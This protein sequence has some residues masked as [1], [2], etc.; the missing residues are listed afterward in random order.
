[1]K[2][3]VT[4]SVS[5]LMLAAFLLAASSG[6]VAWGQVLKKQENQPVQLRAGIDGGIDAHESGAICCS[7][8]ATVTSSFTVENN[9]GPGE[10]GTLTPKP[11]APNGSKN[12]GRWNTE[13]Q[14]FNVHNGRITLGGTTNH[15]GHRTTN[16]NSGL[17]RVRAAVSV[18]ASKNDLSTTSH[19]DKHNSTHTGY[20]QDGQG[21]WHQ[22]SSHSETASCPQVVVSIST[23]T[24]PD[25]TGVTASNTDPTYSNPTVITVNAANMTSDTPWWLQQ[26][27]FMSNPWYFYNTTFVPNSDCTLSVAFNWKKPTVSCHGQHPNTSPSWGESSGIASN[28]I[29]YEQ[30]RWGTSS[31]QGGFVDARIIV[32]AGSDIRL[33]GADGAGMSIAAAGTNGGSKKFYLDLPAAHYTLMNDKDVAF[34]NIE[35]SNRAPLGDSAVFGVNTQL[36]TD[37]ST[38]A[39]GGTILI[40]SATDAASQGHMT[41]TASTASVTGKRKAF[42][43]SIAVGSTH[44][45]T[46]FNLPLH[47]TA[48]FGNYGDNAMTI[49][50][51]KPVPAT[52]AA[53]GYQLYNHSCN[54]LIFDVP[55]TQ[56]VG[57]AGNLLVEAYK[58]LSFPNGKTSTIT[59]NGTGDATFNGGDVSILADHTYTG[60]AVGDYGIYAYTPI[61]TDAKSWAALYGAPSFCGTFLQP[62]IHVQPVNETD[63]TGD[64][65]NYKYGG[66]IDDQHDFCGSGNIVFGAVTVNATHTAAGDLR[67][68]ATHDINTASGSTIGFTHSGDGGMHWQAKHDINA[69]GN[70]TFT[71]SGSGKAIWQAE[72]DITTLAPISTKV[73]FPLSGDGLT[74]WQATGNITTNNEIEFNNTGTGNVFWQAGGDITTNY[75]V[76][77]TNTQSAHTMWYAKKNITTNGGGGTLGD[78]V[79]FDEQGTGNNIWWAETG[80]ITTNNNVLFEHGATSGNL[81]WWAGRNIVVSGNPAAPNPGAN[82]NQLVINKASD[83]LIELHTVNG[84]IRTNSQVD[85]NRTNSGAGK[86]HLIAGCETYTLDNNIDIEN[87]FN[88]TETAGQVDGLVKWYAENDI[89]S[90]TACDNNRPAPITFTVPAASTT[91]TVWEAQR[92]INTKGRVDF[93]YG[94]AV[95]MGDLVWLSRGGHI[96]TE[97]PG[98]IQYD[99]DNKISLRAE[100][101]RHDAIAAG[102]TNN[103]NASGRRGNIHFFDSID[104]KRNNANNGVTEIKAENHIWTA[105]LNYVDMQSAGNIMDIISHKGDI[106][107]GYN[108]AKTTGYDWK[109]YVANSDNWKIT[110][111]SPSAECMFPPA[112]PVSYDLNRFTYTVPAQNQTGHLWIKAGWEEK[113]DYK[114]VADDGTRSAGGNIYFTHLDVNQETGSDHSTEITIPF[115]GLWRCGSTE[116]GQLYNRKGDSMQYY[117]NA[118]IIGGVSRC[119]VPYPNTDNTLANDISLIY[120]GGKGNLNVDAGTRGNIILNKGGLINFQDPQNTGNVTFRTRFG[121]IDMRD[122]FNADSITGSLLFLAQTENLSDL[123]KVGYCGCEEERNNVYLQDFQYKA[124][125]ASGS[126]FVGADNNIKLNYGGLQNKGTHY[127][128]FLSTDYQACPDGSAAKIGSGYQRGGGCGPMLHCDMHDSVNQARNLI[129][130]FYQDS[131]NTDITSGGFAAVA[132]DYIDVYKSLIYTGGNGSG[133]SA[134]PGTGTLHGESV[135]GYGLYMK[136]QANKNNWNT[137]IFKNYP[138]CPMGCSDFECNG[139]F[140]HMISRMTFHADARIYAHNQRVYLGSP[141]IESFGPMV[142]NTDSMSG[143]RTEIVIQTDSLILHDSLVVKGKKLRYRSWSGLKNDRPI[144]KFGYMRRTPPFTE[145]TKNVCGTDLDVCEPCHEYIRGSKDPL[146]MLDTI[147]VKFEEGAYLERLNS[148]VFDHTVLTFLTDS[149]DHVQG[150][151]VEHAKIYVDTLK[152][153]NQVDLYADAKHERDAHFELIS[154]E[155]MSSKNYAGV[156][157][158]HYHMEP[159]GPCGRNYSELW[160]SDDLALDVIT[161]STFGGF[162]YQHSDVHVETEAHLNPGFTSLRLRGQCYEQK[163]GTLRM[164]DLRLDGGSQ[165]H[166]SVGTTKGINGEYSDAIDVELLTTYG[167]VDVNIEVRPCERMEN[168]CYP[169]IYYKSQTPGSVKNLNLVPKRMKIGDVEVPLALDVSQEGVVYLCVGNAVVPKTVYSVTIPSVVGVT[170]T[171]PAGIAYTLGHSNFEFRAKYSTEKPFVVRTDRMYNGLKEVLEGKKN[172]N[173]EYE[174]VITDV[175]QHIVL[176]FG[177]DH[178]ANMSIDGTAVWSHGETIYIRVER[179]DIASIYSVAGQLVKRIELPEGDT[180]ISMQRGAYVVTL[181]DGSVHKVIVK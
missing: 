68:Q 76:K 65:K 81:S 117:E 13:D 9:Y 39:A 145:Y 166:F 10:T 105:M 99:S 167:T 16:A 55:Y 158:R 151:P 119:V 102:A 15:V 123:S 18:T 31:G 126:I 8:G 127:D 129:L 91:T 84:Y 71:R 157:A 53:G 26:F 33:E 92:N 20:W 12:T 104:I 89:L 169:I 120:R 133:M 59:G 25:G 174:Y 164:K 94:G 32:T 61:K 83:E 80:D 109:Y 4:S 77:F 96:Q 138:K 111:K 165:L 106:Y 49:R 52:L 179:E 21:N 140:L 97:R 116:D 163:C 75:K 28:S 86:T 124:H 180:S 14:G 73:S 85:I 131:T 87:E 54:D 170:T 1:M 47:G 66:D 134:V 36:D 42:A 101:D 155:Q 64:H 50:H 178:V 147:T 114:K 30:V 168:R 173:G 70:I 162:G 141:V 171:P 177:P 132:S 17:S 72:H 58:T 95:G 152:V 2:R 130:N 46:G 3:K 78:D 142:L 6:G 139:G 56:T 156:Y 108:D 41:V 107:L 29:N 79:K 48:N 161:T 115:S 40:G 143:G 82:N 135:A 69:G 118:G 122:P 100:D 93:K 5:K 113:T 121:D 63:D 146:H 176:T 57:G 144:M 98:T 37:I 181:K 90:N 159:I 149:F 153:R 137:N 23:P 45:Y 38:N 44:T 43:K 110:Q 7:G 175:T 112:N 22:A 148:V 128:P 74:A 51:A 35:V 60:N 160:L 136:T 125:G 34:T 67:W 88:Y 172:A 150:P 19:C 154:E 24:V 27:Y 11:N 62:N 103:A